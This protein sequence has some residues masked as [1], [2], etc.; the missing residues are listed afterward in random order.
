MNTGRSN[1]DDD[2]DGDDG[3]VGGFGK[4]ELA[5]VGHRVPL[6]QRLRHE[7]LVEVGEELKRKLRCHS[8]SEP[9]EIREIIVCLKA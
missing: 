3:E 4:F 8:E 6:E 9:P 5:E 7:G 2:V 1:L